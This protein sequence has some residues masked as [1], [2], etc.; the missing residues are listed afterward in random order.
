MQTLSG[1]E[2]RTVLAEA[3]NM[4]FPSNNAASCFCGHK[5]KSGPVISSEPCCTL[6][7]II[8]C[9]TPD[10]SPKPFR[11]MF[12]N[13]IL[14]LSIAASLGVLGLGLWRRDNLLSSFVGCCMFVC[15]LF[16]LVC[17]KGCG[18]LLSCIAERYMCSLI[19]DTL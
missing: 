15:G 8:R 19:L 17:V 7:Q 2:R 13:I 5:K 12:P 10:H 11:F 1:Q 3:L 16:G 6:G 18:S 4:C 14:C 9:T